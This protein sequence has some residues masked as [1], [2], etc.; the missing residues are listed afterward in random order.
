MKDIPY[1]QYMFLG[2]GPGNGGIEHST[3][4]ANSFTGDALKTINGKKGMLS[5]LAYEYFHNYNVKR[6]RPIELGPFDGV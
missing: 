5:F 2:I 6:M 3:S 1:E 4:S